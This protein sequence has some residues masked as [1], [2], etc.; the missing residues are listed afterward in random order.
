[1]NSAVSLSEY[2]AVFIKW[3][4]VFVEVFY[5]LFAFVIVRQ[6]TLMNASFS[7]QYGK[8]FSLIAVFHLLAALILLIFSL[9]FI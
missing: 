1:M 6:V 9:I 4:F 2:I 8:A 3:G 7:T 5:V